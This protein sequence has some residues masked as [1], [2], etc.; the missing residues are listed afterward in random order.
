MYSRKSVVDSLSRDP[1]KGSFGRSLRLPRGEQEAV[2]ATLE[3]LAPEQKCRGMFFRGVLDAARFSAAEGA[4]FL[5]SLDIPRPTMPFGLYPHVGFYKLCFAAANRLSPDA[6]MHEG[7]FDLAS[8]FYPIFSE[9]VVGRTMSPLMGREPLTILNRLVEAYR[10]C[11]PM[12]RHELH[13]TGDRT[14]QWHAEVETCAFYAAIFRG[15]VVGTMR[16]QGVQAPG[17]ELLETQPLS[18]GQKCVFEIGW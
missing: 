6:S 11:V 3:S 16:T 2:D 18:K 13:R 14:A 17:V 4:R 9:S 15:I 12:N 10:L 5:E 1:S 7:L 8:D